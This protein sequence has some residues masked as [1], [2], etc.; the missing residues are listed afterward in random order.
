MPRP[1]AK[2]LAALALGVVLALAPLA[3]AADDRGEANDAYLAV[4]G[5][6]SALGTVV[7]APLKIVYAITGTV[8][9]GL[10]W[11]WTAGD[12][13]LAGTIFNSAAGGDYV[14]TPAHV[15]GKR[16]LRVM[17]EAY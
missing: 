11:V 16:S 3:A 9:S 7:Y 12:G 14:I 2:R 1:A 13:D 15:E 8:I 5:I 4:T 17:G 10:A 6:A